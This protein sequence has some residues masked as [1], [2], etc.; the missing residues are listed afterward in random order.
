MREAYP[1]HPEVF[2]R[3]YSDWSTLPSFQRTRG[4]LRLMAAVIHTLWES[5]DRNP[6]ILPASIPLDDGRVQFELT[7]YL[8][9]NWAPVNRTR[10]RRR[11]IAARAT[12]RGVPQS[13]SS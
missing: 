10:H 5:G 1:V 11:R 4:V 2:E 9:A 7:R 3:L 6:L 8:P 13:R 12:G